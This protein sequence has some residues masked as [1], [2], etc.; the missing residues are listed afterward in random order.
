MKRLIFLCV[1]FSIATLL[2][3]QETGTHHIDTASQVLPAFDT[4]VADSSMIAIPAG[5]YD[6]FDDSPEGLTNAVRNPIHYFGH[7]FCTVFAEFKFLV[8]AHDIAY[9]AEIAYVPEV[10][11]VYAN[12]M[13]GK[14]HDWFTAGAEYRLSS[15]WS[16]ADWHLYGG[17]TGGRFGGGLDLGVRLAADEE[18]N[19]GKFAWTS[20]SIG[21]RVTSIGSFFM[22]GFSSALMPFGVIVL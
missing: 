1:A 6:E 20:G 7:H 19:H 5:D 13:T 9:G 17:I 3:A 10:W 14:Y 4:L 16:K 15:P 18:F 11:G 2:S 8:G 12:F 22:L 21:V